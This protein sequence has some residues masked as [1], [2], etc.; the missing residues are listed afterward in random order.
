MLP[1]NFH[2]NAECS[3]GFHHVC[4][5]CRNAD[6]RRVE[7]TKKA[8]RDA[9][10]DLSAHMSLRSGKHCPLCYGLSERVVGPACAKCGLKHAS[11]PRPEFVNRKAV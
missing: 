2:V 5:D 1:E 8:K 7:L 6:K 11:E 4:K 3:G 9:V 10:G